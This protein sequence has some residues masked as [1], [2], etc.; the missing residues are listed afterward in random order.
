MFTARTSLT[1]LTEDFSL[2][3]DPRHLKA[4]HDGVVHNPLGSAAYLYEEE[5]LK[6]I[7]HHLGLIPVPPPDYFDD[8]IVYGSDIIPVPTRPRTDSAVSLTHIP[9]ETI[10]TIHIGAQPNN[11]P[12]AGTI[13]TFALAFIL[14]RDLQAKYIKLRADAVAASPAYT[15]L[16]VDTL[17]VVV[18]LDLVDTAPDASRSAEIGGV[19]Y[20]YSHRAT[21]AMNAFLPDYHTLL[22]E[23][24][25]FT[26]GEV[27]Y[28]VRNQE[29]LMR[30]PA[31]RD[32]I[33]TLIGDRARL[34][35]ELFPTRNAL[36]IRSACPVKDCGCA[37]KHGLRNAY[38]VTPSSTSITFHC[39][40]HGPYTLC[41]EDPDDL[42]RLELNTPLRN[43]ARAIVYMAETAASH[44]PGQPTPAALHMRVTGADY[45][46]EYQER[47]FLHQ[48]SELKK[49]AEPRVRD[50][51]VTDP[52]IVYA[53][54]IL[55]WSGAKLSKSLYVKQDGY[56][57]LRAQKK[58]YFLEF[59]RMCTKDRR[60]L[61]GAV[62]D[63]FCQPAKRFRSYTL[64]YL[65][66]RFIKVG[67][68]GDEEVRKDTA[69]D[70]ED[71]GSWLDADFLK[72]GFGCWIGCLAGLCAGL[73][74]G[75]GVMGRK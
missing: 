34:S 55:D 51:V 67:L 37:D 50:A 73:V 46:G 21:G 48:L 17:R 57:Y 72:R 71:T 70:A 12:H 7:L 74:I 10:L 20:Q 5:H 1:K 45:S 2:D 39:P 8:G 23:L 33:R 4:A 64:E 16:W 26:G 29:E 65:H 47:A 24:R 3:V 61:Y 9:T 62:E 32:A 19:K 40:T 68:R 49:V 22:T 75:V 58:D 18:Q 38:T 42:A 11:S 53:P 27:D 63:W 56:K 14:A 25:A 30:C 59:R 44:T 31:M 15:H 35:A 36:A 43:L 52:V 60:V 41:L 6:P 66:L 28:A 54:L 69:D 13:I